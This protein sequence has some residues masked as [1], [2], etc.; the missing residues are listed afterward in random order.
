MF[1]E[2]EEIKCYNM[3]L[4]K[5]VF[6]I[7]ANLRAPGK[8]QMRLNPK[9]YAAL[10]NEPIEKQKIDGKNIE[11][12]YMNDTPYLFQF[13][14]KGRFSIWTSDGQNFKILI[15]KRYHEMLHDFYQPEINAIW[16]SFM[17]RV[18]N[19]NKK[20][21]K[22][23]L[24]PT[25]VLYLAIAIL[26]SIF[27]SGYT[28]EILIGIVVIMIA[29]R[30]VQSRL[31]NRKVTQENRVAQDEIAKILGE[32]KYAGILKLQELH[33]KEYFKFDEEEQQTE[34][35]S[36]Q[37]EAPVKEEDSSNDNGTKND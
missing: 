29:S 5:G 9:I 14:S 12:H 3:K 10:A 34:A 31:F 6:L 4:R 35:I 37:N 16:L 25:I 32:D 11:I 1:L 33:L 15:E 24:Y 27:F 36:N 13:A 19:I 22:W 17:I 2:N 30:M 21:G 28:T 20:M 26:G 7:Y 23:F 8:K 18:G